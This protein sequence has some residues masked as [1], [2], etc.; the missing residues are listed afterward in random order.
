MR[1]LDHIR[2]ARAVAREG[3]FASAARA[4][5][6]SASAT[7]RAVAEL[8]A[9]LGIQLF[10]RTT[11]SVALTAAGAAYLDRAEDALRLLDKAENEARQSALTPRGRLRISAPLSFGIRYLADMIA[12]FRI[13]YPEV[14]LQVSLTDRFVDIVKED[15]D[16]ALRISGPPTDKSTIWR[17][18]AEMPRMLVASPTYLAEF[19]VPDHPSQLEGHRCLHYARMAEGEIWDMTNGPDQIRVKA[20]QGLTADNGDLLAQLAL[21]GHGIA[22]LPTFLIET[23]LAQGT[24]TPVL[25]NWQAP[26]IWLTAF[27][28]PYDAL[29][30]AVSRFTQVVEGRFG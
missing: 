10:K 2:T 29:P 4:L 18:I 11:R 9:H 3:S 14:D 5:N 8:E 19:G 30:P 22:L 21:K 27:Y 16:M 17:K 12:Q 6:Q 26:P 23:E 24:L 13:L 15:L 25:P 7:T 20:H 28:P 1:T